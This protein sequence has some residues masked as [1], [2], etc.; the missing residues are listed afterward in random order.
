MIKKTIPLF[1]LALAC[2]QRATVNSTPQGNEFGSGGYGVEEKSG[3]YELFDFYETGGLI[4]DAEDKGQSLYPEEWELRISN[5]IPLTSASEKKEFL[6]IFL[7]RLYLVNE[8]MKEDQV[9]VD[10]AER[11]LDRTSQLK[12]KFVNTENTKLTFKYYV[13]NSSIYHDMTWENIRYKNKTILADEYWHDNY[14][15]KNYHGQA[16]RIPK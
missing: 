14:V 6:R 8:Q 5:A 12:W 15:N 4:P 2:A 13:T 11:I 1:F 9:E 7:N 16:I 3:R 10:F